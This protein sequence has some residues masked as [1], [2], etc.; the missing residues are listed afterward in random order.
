MLDRHV[1]LFCDGAIVS[2][3]MQMAEPYLDENGEPDPHHHG[4]WMMEPED[5]RKAFDT[6]WDD[7]WQIHIHVNGDLG[8][9]VLVEIIED[10]TPV[11]TP[12]TALSSCTLRIQ[13]RR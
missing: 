2:Q 10:A 5:L 11:S 7:D 4:E 13:P 6:Y 9:E 12:I 1:K 8:L 3:L